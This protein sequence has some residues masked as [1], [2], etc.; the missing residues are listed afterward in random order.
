MKKMTFGRDCFPKHE[1]DLS[2]IAKHIKDV[3]SD[4]SNQYMI[5]DIVSSVMGV[6]AAYALGEIGIIAVRSQTIKRGRALTATKTTPKR[7]RIEE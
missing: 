3:I 1:K 7:I 5:H 6:S 4:T 2:A